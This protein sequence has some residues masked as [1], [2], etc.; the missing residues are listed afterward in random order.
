MQPLESHPPVRQPSP[1]QKSPTG[2]NRSSAG[3]L[4]SRVL[5]A[6]TAAELLERLAAALSA[7]AFFVRRVRWPQWLGVRRWCEGE[8]RC[9][10]FEAGD[11][12]NSG[13]RIGP[14]LLIGGDRTIDEQAVDVLARQVQSWDDRQLDE[15]LA[16]MAELAAGAGHEVNNPLGSIVGRVSMLL[17]NEPDPERRKTLAAIASQAYRGRDMIGDLMLFARPPAPHPEC[18]AVETVVEEVLSEFADAIAEKSLVVVGQRD[19]SASVWADATQLRIVISELLRNAIRFAPV[20]TTIDVATKVLADDVEIAMTDDGPSL[21]EQERRHLFDPFYS[22]RQAGRGLGF[23]LSKC[24]RIATI[25]GGCVQHHT[26]AGKNCFTVRWPIKT[27][28]QH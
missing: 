2:Q 24:W 14:A 20:S 7:E 17:K 18:V 19:A 3:D 6:G 28:R 11:I 26:S 27:A 22:G 23:G 9:E 1:S 10:I 4:Y 5:P 13:R 16:S 15:K 12:P 8:H 21:S 25:H